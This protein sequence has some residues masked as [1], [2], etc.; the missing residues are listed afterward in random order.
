MTAGLVKV[1]PISPTC[2]STWNCDA[3]IGDDA[4]RFLAAVLQ[5]MQ[6]ERD[7]RRGVLPAENAEHA[8]F[9]VEMIVGL[10]KQGTV[11]HGT[12]FVELQ[13]VGNPCRRPVRRTSGRRAAHIVPATIPR[14]R[15]ANCWPAALPQARRRRRRGGRVVAGGGSAG[16][17]VAGRRGFPC[18]LVAAGRKPLQDG[19]FGIVRQ[20]ALELGADQFQ[21]AAATW[22]R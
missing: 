22:P 12:S 6:A 8:A 11:C 1:S 4:G 16:G 7:D 10:G 18:R 3:V 5:R 14:H 20:Q 21:Q 19:V 15:P 13:P 9:V 2:R 17:V